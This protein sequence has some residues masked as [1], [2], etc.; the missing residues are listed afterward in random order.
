[1]I[2][3]SARATPLSPGR[4]HI[5]ACRSRPSIREFII[6]HI[7][8]IPDSSQPFDPISF[9]FR[10]SLSIPPALLVDL[11]IPND[12]SGQGYLRSTVSNLVSC[13]VL[14]QSIVRSHRQDSI[15]H[16]PHHRSNHR[17]RGRLETFRI[18]RPTTWYSGV[19]LQHSFRHSIFFFS[20]FT[21]TIYSKNNLF[22]LGLRVR[23]NE[24]DFVADLLG[25]LCGTSICGKVPGI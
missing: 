2:N 22:S 6:A 21:S 14:Q 1:M 9:H 7:H 3:I 11:A 13:T 12:G 25:G 18:R 5:E 4:P 15:S 10:H 20:P 19:S 16:L 24:V 8:F 23:Q 17:R